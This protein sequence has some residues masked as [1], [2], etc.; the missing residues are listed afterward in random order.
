MK[1]KGT[2]DD[3][4][5]FDQGSKFAFQLDAGEVIKGWDI[6]IKGSTLFKF[7]VVLPAFLLRSRPVGGTELY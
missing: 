4:S 2:L 7:L 6:G 5:V 3:G 1:Y